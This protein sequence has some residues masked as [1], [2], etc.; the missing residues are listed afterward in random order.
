MWCDS[1]WIPLASSWLLQVL[2]FLK[3]ASL[4]SFQTWG[5]VGGGGGEFCCPMPWIKPHNRQMSLSLPQLRSSL[6]LIG[7]SIWEKPTQ[8][9]GRRILKWT[10]LT[11]SPFKEPRVLEELTCG[12]S[13]SVIVKI[14]SVCPA[15]ECTVPIFPS[16]VNEDYGTHT[17]G[18]YGLSNVL[19][20]LQPQSSPDSEHKWSHYGKCW[21]CGKVGVSHR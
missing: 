16:G 11:Y 14:L 15:G 12:Q 21:I 6:M 1:P 20:H 10:G 4:F 17:H 3:S 8:S 19:A 9:G 2:P 13:A 18:C 7:G 5:G